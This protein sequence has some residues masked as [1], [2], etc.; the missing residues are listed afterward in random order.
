M[1][2]KA[3][4]HHMRKLPIQ[5]L[6]NLGKNRLGANRLGSNPFGSLKLRLG[7]WDFSAP[8]S[9][10]TVTQKVANIFL[11]FSTRATATT[12]TTTA[13]KTC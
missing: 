6:I 12:T 2:A 4:S 5:M 3:S 13:T 7:L 8:K 1:E 10:T 11:G 9:A